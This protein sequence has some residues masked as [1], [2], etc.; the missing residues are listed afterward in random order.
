M[1]G[2]RSLIT[3][4]IAIIV[5][6]V[7]FG[8]FKV[9][10]DKA[11]KETEKIV[12]GITINDVNLTTIADGEYEGKFD[13]ILAG[14]HVKVTVKNK[15]ITA[16][17]IIKKKHGPGKKYSAEG[18]TDTVIE[19]QSLKVDTISGATGTSKIILK[20]IELALTGKEQ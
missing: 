20:A 5:I 17:D 2:K 9:K 1:A 14:A 11:M 18:L 10:M 13:A 16:I 8:I 3:V 15:K 19:K 7:L 6:V 4:I 12:E